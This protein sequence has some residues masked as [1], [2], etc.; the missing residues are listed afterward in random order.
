VAGKRT[1]PKRWCASSNDL[2]VMG[3]G[4][5]GTENRVKVTLLLQL[6]LAR[7]S[8]EWSKWLVP[9]DSA[10]PNSSGVASVPEK[11]REK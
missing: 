5:Q 8:M 10:S 6:R 1:P 9:G 3:V 4:E 11:T 2:P 7:R